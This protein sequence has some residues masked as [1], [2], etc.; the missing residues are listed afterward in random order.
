M[1]VLRNEFSKDFSMILSNDNDTWKLARAYD[2][3]NV[4]IVLP[5]DTEELALTFG[6]KKKL[7]KATLMY[8]DRVL[9]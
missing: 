8:M 6:D 5:E 2:L 3:L 1:L 9:D 7:S 4:S